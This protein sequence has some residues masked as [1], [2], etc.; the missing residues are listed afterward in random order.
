MS[1]NNKE[2]RKFRTTW[3][4]T[5]PQRD[6]QYF[7]E[8]LKA[9][10][11]ATNNFTEK[12]NS[13][14]TIQKKYE[15]V[16]ASKG[17]KRKNISA[18]GSGGRTWAAMLRTYS[19]VYLMDDGRLVPTKVGLALISGKNV[20]DNIRKQ[21]LTLQIPN[22]YFNSSGFRPKYEE[23]FRIRPILFLLRLVNSK[24][25]DYYVTKEEIT[26]FVMFARQDSDLKDIIK[27]ISVYRKLD[28]E[29]K[30][31]EKECI[32]LLDHRER[33][34][35]LAR[36]FEAANGDVAHT[37]MLQLSYTELVDYVNATLQ[38][39]KN[40][41]T[42]LIIKLLQEFDERYPFNT[43]YEIS[44]AR[45][46]ESAG[47]DIE[48]YK[49]RVITYEKVASNKSKEHN[50]VMNVLAN[51]PN[52]AGESYDKIFE[53]TSAIFPP[54]KA[55]EMAL[56]IQ[57][58]SGT[59]TPNIDEDFITSYLNQT[60]DL[61]FERQSVEILRAYGFETVIH[62]TPVVE[63]V[64][65][66]IDILIHI[67]ESNVAILDAKNYRKKFALSANLA[68]HMAT[69]YI[70]EYNGYSG[71]KVRYFGYITASR[72]GGVSNMRKIVDK[73]ANYSENLK[74]SGALISASAIL[75]LLDY[76]IENDI[77]IEK[78]K[79][80]FVELLNDNVGYETYSQIAHRLKLN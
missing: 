17:L 33:S 11:E 55:N 71:K 80:Y 32:A 70:P 60:D 50:L 63:G 42:E 2:N 68:N 57:S 73:A 1:L 24:E 74:V 58:M 54:K 14:R 12:W 59:S 5:R 62:P 66:S 23:G 43:R 39:P 46:G 20:Y 48:S 19:F 3:F 45:F 69:E 31:M 38:I 35:K 72:I 40:S 22:A 10:K 4:V 9:L 61:E 36:D 16:L 44:E 26:Y 47:L 75:G 6:P 41:T 51:F 77:S 8:A 18:D 53:I 25:I 56:E 29:D 7:P 65:T 49:S 15:E 27:K 64:R 13:N 52:L 34:D 67:D 76:C 21:L 28:D 37:L 78:R 79:S 30:K